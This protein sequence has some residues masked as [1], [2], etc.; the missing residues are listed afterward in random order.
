MIR[1]A[2]I[3]DCLR[4]S[5]IY[6]EAVRTST[7]SF[8][9]GEESLAEREAWFTQHGPQHPV[10]VAEVDGEVAGWASISRY[11]IRGGYRFTVESSI[12]IARAYHRRGIGLALMDHLLKV[13]KAFGYHSIIAGITAE[14]TASVG[15]HERLGFKQVAYFREVGYKFNRWLDVVQYQLMLED[16]IDDA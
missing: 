14:Q 3:H 9:L 12:Y 2:T 6:N 13:A 7:A 5:E 10:Y 1:D 15:L 8:A 4:I 11:H 16:G